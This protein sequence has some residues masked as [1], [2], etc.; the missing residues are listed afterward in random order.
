MTLVYRDNK[1]HKIKI[2]S[3]LGPG[4]NQDT[5]DHITV[6]VSLIKIIKRMI[7]FLYHL[8]IEVINKIKVYRQDQVAI[9]YKM[10]IIK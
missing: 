3:S 10:L 1:Y 5:Q 7:E 6:K 2:D 4:K 9:T 8:L